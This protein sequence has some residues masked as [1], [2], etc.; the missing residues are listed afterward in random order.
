M[1]GPDEIDTG[2]EL[3]QHIRRATPDLPVVIFTGAWEGVDVDR[4]EL[5][6]KFGARIVFKSQG[7]GELKQVVAA[8]LA[9]FPNDESAAQR[10]PK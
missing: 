8:L 9:D 10:K 3:C 5:E 4:A 7:I 2:F 1:P 6:A